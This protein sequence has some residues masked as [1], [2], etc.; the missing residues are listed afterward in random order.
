MTVGLPPADSLRAALDTVFAGPA[1]RWA[2]PTPLNVTERWWERLRTWLRGLEAG[3]PTFF[4]AVVIVLI[5]ALAVILAHAA[6]VA[7]RTLRAT[8]AAGDRAQ[9]TRAPM[10]DAAWHFAEADRLAAA[11]RRTEAMRLA[12][13]GVSLALDA[14]DALRYHPSQT[15]AEVARLARLREPERAR[16]A[17]LVRGLYHHVFAGAPCAED[18][19]RAWRER[20]VGAWH[21][22]AH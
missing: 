3:S 11:G 13:R 2:P 14:V 6:W 8:R 16:L 17:E 5:A 20:A 9:T 19:W 15:P 12:F 18:E 22:A 7:L 10:R 21:A 4:R 1:Y